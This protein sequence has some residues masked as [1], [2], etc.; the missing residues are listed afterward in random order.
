MDP[1]ALAAV[2]GLAFV[3]KQMSDS[4]PVSINDK[5][6][7]NTV[8]NTDI[9]VIP[10]DDPRLRGNFGYSKREMTNFTDVSTASSR[11]VYGQPVYNMSN[12]ENV[13]NMM[14]NLNPNPWNRVGPGIG[15]GHNVPSYG[16][17]QQLAREMP[18]NVNEYRLT[19]LEGRVQAPPKSVVPAHE[20]YSVVS[21]N[22]PDKDYYRAPGKG[23]GAHRG[24]E[25]RSKGVRSRYTTLKEQS[26]RTDDM[27]GGPRYILNAGHVVTG[28]QSMDRT[29]NRSKPDRMANPGRMNVLANPQGMNGAVTTV[30]IDDNTQPV[31][32]GGAIV[33]QGYIRS[34]TQE[35]NPYK[36]TKDFRTDT[37]DLAKNQLSENVYNHPLSA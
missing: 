33:P 1:F 24:P 27:P 32:T 28:N 16:G 7:D 35:V 37:L 11:Y 18:T 19:Q 29:N 13:S 20:S 15:V 25:V 36:D 23:T 4:A 26:M 21:K 14:K 12:R 34:G 17:Y 3:G 9:P 8:K 2:V 6:V 22:R 10:D 31:V 30:R 5:P